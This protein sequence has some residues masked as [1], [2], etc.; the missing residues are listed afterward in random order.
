MPEPFVTSV[1]VLVGSG[2]KLPVMVKLALTK[3]LVGLM[4]SPMLPRWIA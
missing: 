1:M 2:R 4:A 3:M